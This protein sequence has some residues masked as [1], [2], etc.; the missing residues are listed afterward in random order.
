MNKITSF[1]LLFTLLRDSLDRPKSAHVYHRAFTIK[2]QNM[3]S[4]RRLRMAKVNFRNLLRHED[5]S[6]ISTNGCGAG[7][8]SITLIRKLIGQNEAIDAEASWRLKRIL[9]FS[10]RPLPMPITAGS[11]LEWH[12]YE[13]NKSLDNRG[14][15][16]V[17]RVMARWE[18]SGARGIMSRRQNVI[19]EQDRFRCALNVCHRKAIEIAQKW[20]H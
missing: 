2:Y 6:R 8:I 16:F 9:R 1:R 4:P 10:R 15:E 14:Q 17:M 7:Q 12:I 19:T 18:T 3:N 5:V 13:R 11:R 20:V